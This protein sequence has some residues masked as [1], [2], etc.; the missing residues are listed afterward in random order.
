MSCLRD[1]DCKERVCQ[2]GHCTDRVLYDRCQTSSD[3]CPSGSFCH[4]TLK[5]C[6]PRAILSTVLDSDCE[7]GKCCAW[8][9]YWNGARCIQKSGVG[10]H[11]QN[12]AKQNYEACEEGTDCI[13]GICLRRCW[14]ERECTGRDEKCRED[15]ELGPFRHCYDTHFQESLSRGTVDFMTIWIVLLVILGI[16]LICLLVYGLFHAYRWYRGSMSP[17]SAHKQNPLKRDSLRTYRGTGLSPEE[18]DEDERQF[19]ALGTTRPSRGL[20]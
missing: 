5:R 6:Y 7:K 14:D 16:G 11:C 10:M 3:A 2:G 18:E 9:Q 20:V 8:N 13:Q 15:K 4:A 17:N 12:D 1:S 19:D